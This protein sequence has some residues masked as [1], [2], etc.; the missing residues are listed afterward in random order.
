MCT[1]EKFDPTPAINYWMAKKKRHPKMNNKAHAQEW[2]H[3]V[4]DEATHKTE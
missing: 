2:F 3:G 4:F 1:L